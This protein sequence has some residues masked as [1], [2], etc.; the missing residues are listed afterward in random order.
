MDTV[1]AA[2]RAVRRRLDWDTAGVAISLAIIAAACVALF[3]LLRDV[4][5]GKIVEALRAT[6]FE[7]V[8]VAA[9]LV[10]A[11]YAT[12]TFYDYFALRT[13]G[14]THVPYRTAA[15]TALLSYIVG[16]N[17]GATVLTG[18][19]VRYRIYRGWGLGLVDVARIAFV[20]GLTFWLGNAFV[21][22]LGVAYAPDAAGA[23]NWLPP[24][25]NRAA[26]LAALAA[27]AL[28]LLWL[29]PQPR[30]LG[31]SDWSVTL[32]SARLTLLQI[33]IGA[34]DLSLAA[35]AMFTLVSVHASIDVITV[36][37]SFVIAA[38]LGFASHAPGSLGVFDAAMLLGLPQVE[39]EQLL[40]ALLIFRLLYY[41]VPF[42]L[43]VL[44]LVGR[45]LWLAA[46]R[47]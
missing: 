23:I 25:L 38:L 22:G 24:W 47:T 18:G 9:L 40:A 5:G 12:L 34:A 35:L 46:S 31:R 6:P 32:P 30:V 29:M 27:I 44:I 39:K 8:A 37:V 41:V 45:E 28:Y 14:Q 1:K 36:G 20:T 17:L 42:G 19:V 21:L 7:A 3:H 15:L 11:S 43:A 10:T 13:I 2:A 4:D 33:G 16:H 26:A